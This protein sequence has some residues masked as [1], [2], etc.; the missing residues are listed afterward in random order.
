M[1]TSS[2]VPY[3]RAFERFVGQAAPTHLHQRGQRPYVV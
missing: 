2:I 3:S 1:K